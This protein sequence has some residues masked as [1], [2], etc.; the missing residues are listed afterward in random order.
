MKPLGILILLCIQEFNASQRFEDIFSQNLEDRF[1]FPDFHR[2][3]QF[4]G[5]NSLVKFEHD[6]VDRLLPGP[7][8]GV[9][10]FHEDRI[11]GAVPEGFQEKADVIYEYPTVHEYAPAAREIHHLQ[12]VHHAFSFDHFWPDV[13]DI[14][15]RRATRESDD[16]DIRKALQKSD[17]H[18]QYLNV[19]SK[20]EYE[21]GWNRG[22]PDHFVSRYEQNKDHR[23]RTRVK[24]NDDYGGYGEQYFEYNHLPSYQET[25]Y[26]KEADSVNI[27]PYAPSKPLYTPKKASFKSKY[28]PIPFNTPEKEPYKN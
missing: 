21:F 18:F 6:G 10:G 20:K 22:N 16:G 25:H 4:E 23:F 17:G 26:T 27:I 3:S 28:A 9:D 11:S 5:M 8:S 12:P 24:W 2:F 1:R 15:Y 14:G 13:F 7:D 19:P